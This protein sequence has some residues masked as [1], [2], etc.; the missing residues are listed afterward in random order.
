MALKLLKAPER[1]SDE[2][3]KPES[4]VE[5]KIKVHQKTEEAIISNDLK[6]KTDE[7]DDT[8]NKNKD[9]MICTDKG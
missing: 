1:K 8:D 2:K 4:T 6:N 5:K 3:T 7:K 9:A